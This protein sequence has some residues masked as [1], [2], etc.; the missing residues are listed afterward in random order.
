MLRLPLE[1]A[2]CK[3]EGQ[4]TPEERDA[5]HLAIPEEGLTLGGTAVPK[6]RS[7]VFTD[8]RPFL[9]LFYGYLI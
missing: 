8:S 3:V 1:M 7:G 2:K 4:S 5:L 6:R 9:L